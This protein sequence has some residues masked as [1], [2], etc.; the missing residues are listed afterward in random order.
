MPEFRNHTLLESQVGSRLCKC[1][2]YRNHIGRLHNPICTNVTDD[3]GLCEPCR[4]ALDSG[5][6]AAHPCFVC[7][8]TGTLAGEPYDGIPPHTC[9]ACGGS[10][11]SRGGA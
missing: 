11:N 4:A 2:C 3:D 5:R 10:G 8:G 6:E 7:Q 1:V 9:A